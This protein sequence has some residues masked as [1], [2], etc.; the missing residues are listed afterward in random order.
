MD[1]TLTVLLN[2]KQTSGT[3][4]VKII[5][6]INNQF[7]IIAD[8]TS[9][10]LLDLTAYPNYSS[11]LIPEASYKLIK[12]TKDKETITP[13]NF[14]P[15]KSK[16]EIKPTQKGTDKISKLEKQVTN[17]TSTKSENKIS[18]KDIEEKTKDNT[19]VSNIKV[20]ITTI[21]RMIETKNGNYKIASIADEHS[22]KATLNLYDKH[23]DQIELGKIYHLEKVKK[24]T[25]T[26]EGQK[27]MRLCAN[28][29]STMQKLE[30]END[31]KPFEDIIIGDA[32]VKATIDAIV[33]LS[34]YQAC[35]KHFYKI[36]PEKNCPACNEQVEHPK[37][38][39]NAKFYIST[40]DDN[41]QI[42][43]FKRQVNHIFDVND[44]E[45]EIEE[46]LN[47][48][49]DKT[50]FIDY[51]ENQDQQLILMKIK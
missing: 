32:R 50:F 23:A 26:K 40:D 33:D 2:S 19:L 47:L 41:L 35:P 45:D 37:L 14:Q 18:L 31:T 38:D 8:K 9:Y 6:K 15:I 48:L 3:I 36:D 27:Q 43:F 39:F 42:T 49:V 7:Y 24:I 22:N 30:D 51:K 16:Q 5:K 44:T 34:F 13:S 20:M 21:S 25:I 28:K 29:F 4:T 46:K 10:A 17:I 12:V 11:L 1:N